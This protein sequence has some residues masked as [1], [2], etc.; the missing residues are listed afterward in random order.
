MDCDI[1]HPFLFVF[2]QKCTHSSSHYANDSTVGS[3]A[4]ILLSLNVFSGGNRVIRHGWKKF[5]SWEAPSQEIWAFGGKFGQLDG[6]FHFL[7]MMKL[8]EDLWEILIPSWEVNIFSS[9]G[10]SLDPLSIHTGIQWIDTY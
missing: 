7:Y 3:L 6:N 9:P 5:E 8:Q 2:C 1:F 4:A 10:Y